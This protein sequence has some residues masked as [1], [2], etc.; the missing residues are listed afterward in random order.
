MKDRTT[1]VDSKFLEFKRK[2]DEVIERKILFH[3][4]TIFKFS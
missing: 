4:R 2:N 3:K 1:D